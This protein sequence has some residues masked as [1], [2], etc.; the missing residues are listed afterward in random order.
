MPARSLAIEK[1]TGVILVNLG[2]PEQPS[3]RSVGRFL[4]QFLSDPR[5]VEVPRFLWLPLLTLIIVPSR[6]R[7]SARAYQ[8][9]WTDRGSPLRSITEDQA[10]ALHKHSNQRRGEQIG[11]SDT[12][13]AVTWAMTYGNP[14][15]ESRINEFVARGIDRILIFPLYPQYS[16]TTTGAV[17]DQLATVVKKNRCIPDI[18]CVRDYHDHPLYIKAL[19]GSIKAHWHVAGRG[20]RLLMS[21]HG[22]PEKY[23]SKGD[24]YSLQCI[25]TAELVAAELGLK[26]AE[27]AYSFQS[28]FGPAE[29]VKPYTDS[30][31]SDWA[32]DGVKTAD[33]ICPSFAADCL[34]TLEEI[35]IQS[36]KL[37]IDQGGKNLSVIEC[38]NSSLAH[39][40]LME[41][42]VFD[43]S[44]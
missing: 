43:H 40:D 15:I 22:L 7:Q 1:K 37:F 8:K 34:E 12:D 21:F 16:A 39:I 27:W 6:S 33:V 9:I 24:P 20:Q 38:L 17:Y 10:V 14:T 35:G 44:W 18:R 31:L 42:I 2:T 26:A 19:V 11:D 36:S 30:I 29:W 13:I 41:A 5:V 23:A 3:P 25:R 32:T 28:R 4:R